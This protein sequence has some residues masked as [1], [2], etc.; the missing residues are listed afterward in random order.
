[1]RKVTY[2]LIKKW[3]LI[4]GFHVREATASEGPTVTGEHMQIQ[5]ASASQFSSSLS[6][7]EMASMLPLFLTFV[8]GQKKRNL[9]FRPIH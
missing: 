3:H 1:M 8:Q 9:T 5:G 2:F 6:G 7:G 4:P